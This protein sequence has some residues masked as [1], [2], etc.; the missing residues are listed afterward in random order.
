MCPA[1]QR[2][3]LPALLALLA[4]LLNSGCARSSPASNGANAAETVAPIVAVTK[5]ERTE[6]TKPEVLAAEFRPFQS[7]DIHAKV[8]GYIKKIYVDVGDHVKEGQTIA[9]LEVPELTDEIARAKAA[10]SRSAS[11]VDRAKEELARSEAQHNA[12]HLVFERLQGVAKTRPNLIAQQEID[13]ARARDQSA[14]AGVSA[15][16]AALAAS[17]QGV[18]VSQAD[19]EKT[20]TLASYTKIVAPFAGVVTKRYADTGAMIPAGTAST[21]NG[22]PVVQISQNSRLRLVLPVPES[23]VPRI[24]LGQ[25]VEVRVGALGRSF[26]GKVSRFADSVNTATRTMDTQVDVP[27]PTGVLV[28]GMY[29][30]ALLTL[31]RR[32]DALA[33]PLQALNIQP[34]AVTAMVVGA[35]NKIEIHNLT[36]GLETPDRAEVLSGLNQGDLV[37]T[38]NRNQLAAGQVIQPQV[39]SSNPSAKEKQD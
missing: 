9:V 13:D 22:L 35:G 7:V 1:R 32:A 39:A 20:Q 15:A 16:R 6:L 31:D 36:L 30:E 38:G 24:H 29:A 11:E 34:G 4:A 27:N 2:F 26:R 3:A 28:P 33:V 8:A 14:E 23:T 10:K 19:V 21:S 17:R 12:T 25:P 18:D 5:A 37:V